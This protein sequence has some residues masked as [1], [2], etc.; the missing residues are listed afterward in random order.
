MKINKPY[1]NA[2]YA[3]LAVYCN[4]SGKVI[5]DKGDYLEAVNL[6]EPTVE[7]LQA[8]VRAVRNSYLE[9]YVDP[10][11]L[12]MVWDSLSADDKKLYADYRQY[13]LDYPQTE[14][15]YLQNPM[16]LYEWK[17]SNSSDSVLSEASESEEVIEDGLQR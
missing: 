2:Q 12:V 1:T 10:K 13:L 9:T 5:E 17:E 8:E 14:G 3:D 11:Q 7:E 4:N 16:T 6:P 15:W